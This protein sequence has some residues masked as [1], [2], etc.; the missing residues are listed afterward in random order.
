M[1]KAGFCQRRL[2]CGGP[3]VRFH[4][5]TSAIAFPQWPDKPPNLWQS[6]QQG[7]HPRMEVNFVFAG[8]T[9]NATRFDHAAVST[10]RRSTI[11]IRDRKHLKSISRY[12]HPSQSRTDRLL[13]TEHNSQFAPL[14][15]SF[16]EQPACCT[17]LPLFSAQ[18]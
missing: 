14:S 11:Q 2:L 5:V 18:R 13:R 9:E 1:N 6:L 8:I 16:L 15:P 12:W 3:N 10:K 4:D 17:W 7:E